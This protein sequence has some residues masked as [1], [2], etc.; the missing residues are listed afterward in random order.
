MASSAAT[1]NLAY[2]FALPLDVWRSNLSGVIAQAMK[3][4]N[5][6]LQEWITLALSPSG[7]LCYV[8]CGSLAF[9]Y[10]AAIVYTQ[11]NLRYITAL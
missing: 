3:S 9:K 6:D 11:V 5:V 2:S 4:N 7:M 8:A 10:F 1:M